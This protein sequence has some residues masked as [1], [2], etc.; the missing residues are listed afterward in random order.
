ME[1][2]GWFVSPLHT[3]SRPV[4]LASSSQIISASCLSFRSKT[5]SPNIRLLSSDKESTRLVLLL[6]F[7]YQSVITS[8]CKNPGNKTSSP[9]SWARIGMSRTTVSL[10]SSPCHALVLLSAFHN[11]T[12]SLTDKTYI[13]RLP[14][15]HEMKI[16]TI[17]S[18]HQKSSQQQT[19]L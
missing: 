9:P 19:S 8:L 7:D 3:V 17:V 12:S 15:V 10:T 14:A 4:F 1:L 16:K 2:W 6:T 5:F 18:S 13:W 11:H